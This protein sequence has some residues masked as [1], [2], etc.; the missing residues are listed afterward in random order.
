MKLPASLATLALA[1]AIPTLPA[2]PDKTSPQIS[3]ERMKEDVRI[4]SSDEFLG[5]G[6]GEAGDEKTVAY[7]A[8]AF[9]KAGLEPAGE[10]NSYYQ[11]VPLVRLDRQP[12]AT[13]ALR[14]A[15]KTIPLKLGSNA[16]LGLRNPERSTVDNAPLVFA[17]YGIVD[18][19][20]GWD[21][22]EGVD[23]AGK[24]VVVLAN[25]PDFEAGRDLG[26]EG[27]RMAYGGRVGVKF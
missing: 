24:I 20:R 15:G 6:P 8:G 17:G 2:E 18:A 1:L 13:M 12:G 5:R 11:D 3:P 16:T 9:A 23:V 7:L 21:A 22:Y 4:L 14:L 26:F 25:D 10:N 19:P 27:R